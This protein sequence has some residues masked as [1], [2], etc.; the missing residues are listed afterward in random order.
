MA[1][2]YKVVKG[3]TLSEIAVKYNT[4]VA[5]LAELNNIKNVNLIYVGQVLKIDGTADPIKTNTSSKCNITAFGLQSNTTN[6]LFAIWTWDRSDQTDHYYVKWDY[7]TGDG[8]WFKGSY[9]ENVKEKQSTYNHPDNATKVRF[10]VKPIAKSTTSGN[11]TTYKFTDAEWSTEKIYNVSDSPP[12][13]PSSAPSVTIEGY[14]LTA[15]YTNLDLNATKITFQV[16]KNNGTSAYKTSTVTITN[17][18]ASATWTVDAGAEYMVRAR[19]VRGDLKSDWSPYSDDT[20]TKPTAPSKI[21]SIKATSE[22]SILLKWSKVAS[23]DTYDVEYATKESYF[24]GS[25]QTTTKTGIETNQYEFG[26]LTSGEEYFFRVRAVNEKGESSWTAIKSVVIGESPAAPTTWSSAD[27]VTV[28]D[29][30]TLYWVHNAEDGSKQTYA[31]VE[32]YVDGVKETHTI[33]T[34]ADE[35][36]DNE[37]YSYEVNTSTYDEGVTIEWRV[38]TAGITNSYGEWSVQRTVKV[39]APPTL[40]LY[41]TDYTGEDLDVLTTF[42]I[43]INAVA[44][45]D[46][47]KVVGYRITIISNGVYETVD[48]VGKIKMVNKGEEVY[49]KH[50]DVTGDLEVSISAGDVDLENNVEYTIK[51]LVAM[52]SGLTASDDREFR[53]SWEEVSY[54]PMAEVVIDPESYVAHIRPHCEDENGVLLSDTTLAVYRK[55]FDGTFTEIMS[56]L[57]NELS[58][59][60]TDPHPTLDYARYR[61]VAKTGAT[62]AIRYGEVSVPVNV[63]AVIIQWDEDWSNFIAEAEGETVDPAWSG[64]TLVLPYDIDVS[65]KYSPDVSLVE[66]IGRQHPVSYYGTQ[67]GVTSTWNV[68]IDATDKETIYALRRL[69]NWMGD[70]YVREPSGSGY[71]ANITV[72]FPQK[73]LELVV[74]VTFEIKRVEGGI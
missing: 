64:S 41:A 19:S 20:T 24:N 8:H 52:D 3:D 47:Q 29:N 50:F 46:T 15:T 57:D 53:V 61:I 27:T 28:G 26:N 12:I 60:V 49:S 68:D 54:D 73:H 40:S 7:A 1:T 55:N 6:T 14:K 5:K 2:T 4:T 11:K 51:G 65:D 72:S 70:V 22:T 30:L 37:T 48:E 45:P 71:W 32:M 34:E 23:A 44:G 21:T 36:D 43:N 56:G 33:R 67:R 13:A 58:T 59:F 62:G 25:D 42:P 10:K 17:G 31:E 18:K 74:P 69:A 38:R 63:H 16:R 66:Y 35:D 9:D 39:H